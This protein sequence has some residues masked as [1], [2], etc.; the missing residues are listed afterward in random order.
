MTFSDAL[1]ALAD[2]ISGGLSLPVAL[3]RW[4]ES[5]DGELHGRLREVGARIRLGA[6]LEE[7]LAPLRHEPDAHRMAVL[8]CL[9]AETGASIEKM[10]RDLAD[11]IE[12]RDL[13][14][15]EAR[16]A[17][18]AARASSRTLVAMALLVLPILVASGVPVADGLGVGLVASG[19]AIAL[20]GARW[21][22]AVTPAP[23]RDDDAILTAELTATLL[24][25][26]SDV[27][28]AMDALAGVRGDGLLARARSWVR[29]GRTWPVALTQLE[30]DGFVA[31][32]HVL[33]RCNRA[34]IPAAGELERFAA[35]RRARRRIEFERAARE[36]PVRMVVP[37][38]VC[39]L[40]AFCFMVVAP[41]LR[42]ISTV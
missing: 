23:P 35:S 22:E 25:S 1:R 26:G 40:P 6:G 37:V 42:S 21:V 29:L 36:A 12:R 41:L 17:A 18:A 20:A 19:A 10:M 14:R 8:A 13:R 39:G 15:R 16:A 2:L 33:D 27:N 5:V 28:R 38:V 7:G 24:R 9:G 4:Y 32:G 31:L 30:E 11:A 3:A 34:G